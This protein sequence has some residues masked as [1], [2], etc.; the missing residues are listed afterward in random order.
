MTGPLAITKTNIS[1]LKRVYTGKV[2]DIYEVSEGKW[3]IVS[4]DRISAFDVV[5]NEGIPDK[6]VVLN[7]VSNKWFSKIDVL[8]NHLLSVNPVEELPFLKDYA[9]LP[10]RSV[11][12]KKVN[13]LPVECVVRGYVLGSVW[14]EYCREG[15]VC[16][17]RLPAG[18]QFAGKLPEPLFTPADKAEAGHDENIDYKRFFGVVGKETGEKIIDA[19]IKIYTMANKAVADKGIIL[20]D[21]KFEFGIDD[22]GKL[23]LVDE[24]LT[25]DS[26][27]YWAGATYKPGE[28]PASYDK[29]F[30]RDYLNTLTWNKQPPAPPLPADIISRTRDK[31]LE[32]MRIIES[33]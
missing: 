5:F 14:D 10:E 28:S 18:I 33:I 25:P 19:A 15:S 22:D 29:Q 23:I 6:G 26:S 4:T 31:Y 8:P 7:T 1:E 9:G 11:I 17:I 20:A 27:R 24:V 12:V 16:G 2:R 21:T 3:L 13:R 32:I 30:V